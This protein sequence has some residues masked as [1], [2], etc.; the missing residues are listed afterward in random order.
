MEWPLALLII[1]GGGM[2]L[3]ATGMP[4][5]FALLMITPVGAVLF[6][7]GEAGLYQLTTSMFEAVSTFTL[8]PIPLFVL[9]G[10][11]MF[12]S[13]M[14]MNMIDVLD[15]WLGRVPGRLGL[16]TVTGATLFSTMSGSS[17]GTTAMLGSVLVPEMEQ[18]GHKKEMIIGPI[19]ASGGLAMIIP[20]SGLAVLLAA[21]AEISIADLLI[22]GIIPG[23]I[24][25]FLYAVY[26]VGRC[27][28]QPSLAPSYNV[29]PTPISEKLTA[30]VKYVL[31][32]GFIIFLVLGLI[33]LGVATPSE[34]AAM[35]ALG[36]FILAGLY[37]KFNLT[38]IKKSFMGTIRITIMTFMAIMA[39]KSFSQI[40]ASSGATRGIVEL[41]AA[42]PLI[43]IVTVIAMQ[44]ILIVLGMF[45][46]SV[47]MILITIP[48]FFPIINLLGLNE[49]WF[50]LLMLI[51]MEMAMTTPPYGMILFVM[52]G[53]SP[54]GTTMSEIYKAGF[55]F[56]VCDFIV[57]LLIILFPVLA[58]WLPGLM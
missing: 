46:G 22:A 41:M 17:I 10:E 36:S 58:L 40:L 50:A 26:I 6:W 32:Q 1:L 14:A 4:V 48:I 55:P 38:L 33:F 5:A 37:R 9:L 30:T 34:S 51:N 47:S 16:L 57:M 20:P 3:M 52:K 45:M 21:I 53:V 49:I 19:M 28:I 12:H 24:I 25:A 8:L 23:L 42:I 56:L 54:P 35:G 44:L 11:V 27:W 15:K 39:A 7:N 18:R 43:P 29:V 31:P 13:G 2:V